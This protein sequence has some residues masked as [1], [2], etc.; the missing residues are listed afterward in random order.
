[1]SLQD[2]IIEELLSHYAKRNEA[3]EEL[4]ELLHVGKDA[5]Y[6][7]LRGESMLRPDEIALLAKTY[8]FSLDALLSPKSGKISFSFNQFIN[9]VRSFENYLEGILQSIEM[10]HQMQDAHLYY[11]SMEIPVFHYM[12]FPGLIS[13]KLYAWGLTSWDFEFLEKMDFH[14]ELVP[15]PALAISREI[16]RLYQFLPSTELWSLN[17]VDNTLNQI[18]YI[19]TIGRF[20]DPNDALVLCDQ[21]LQLIAHMRHMAKH[22]AKFSLQGGAGNSSAPFHLYH[23]ELVSTNNTILLSSRQGTHLFTTFENPNF[24]ITTDPVLCRHS[25]QWL[26]KIIGKSNGISAHSEK[27]RQWFFNRLEKKVQTTRKH[28]ELMI[29]EQT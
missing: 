24:L 14:F 10:A 15:P 1:M 6:R 12:F 22:G 26:Q 7:R 4:A 19:L 27:N 25:E 8:H 16:V 29:E 21:A 11:A 2:R 13:F 28:L 20:R 23:N 17:I 18:E 3:V 5:V 9:P